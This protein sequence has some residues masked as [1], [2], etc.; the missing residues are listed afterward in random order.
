M[1][2]ERYKLGRGRVLIFVRKQTS[3]TSPEGANIVYSER[4]QNRR[5]VPDKKIRSQP[6][7]KLADRTNS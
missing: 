4:Q 5:Q 1:D 6:S 7:S 2:Y 3:M